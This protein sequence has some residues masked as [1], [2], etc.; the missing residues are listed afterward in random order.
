MA[1][2]TTDLLLC[3]LSLPL[4][5]PTLKHFPATIGRSFAPN[6]VA[7]AVIVAQLVEWLIATR[8]VCSSNPFIGKIY[9]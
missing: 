6:Y 1:T 9:I 3:R 5:L 4:T 7:W 2:R 8:E